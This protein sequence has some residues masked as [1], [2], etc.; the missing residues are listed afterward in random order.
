MG[1]A[2]NGELKFAF[3]EIIGTPEKGALILETHS[4]EVLV[5]HIFIHIFPETK[6]KPSKG[7]TNFRKLHNIKLVFEFAAT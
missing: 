2:V 3:F 7:A 6:H 1:I 5:R 4:R